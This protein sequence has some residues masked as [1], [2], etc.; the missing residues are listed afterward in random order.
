MDLLKNSGLN[1]NVKKEAMAIDCN[2]PVALNNE[3]GRLKNSCV[4]LQSRVDFIKSKTKVFSCFPVIFSAP[5]PVAQ[6]ITGIAV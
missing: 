3:S 1:V 6:T 4:H 2:H 5:G